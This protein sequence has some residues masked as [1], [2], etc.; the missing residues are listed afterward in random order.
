M[1]LAT[2]LHE[3]APRVGDGD[4]RLFAPGVRMLG[5]VRSGLPAALAAGEVAMAGGTAVALS[6]TRLL[7]PIQPP[8]VRHFVALEERVDAARRSATA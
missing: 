6:D 4:V 8:T 5:V 1:H 7:A 3:G 2:V